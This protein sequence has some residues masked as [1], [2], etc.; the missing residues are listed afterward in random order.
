VRFKE[1]EIVIDS[2]H[3]LTIANER[4]PKSA[5]VTGWIGGDVA[6][7][8]LVS[9]SVTSQMETI[10][11]IGTEGNGGTPTAQIVFSPHT[12][13]KLDATQRGVV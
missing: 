7:S 13:G 5:S 1:N 6:P 11:A 10:S 2:K 4:Q 12:G 3:W 8:I 9:M